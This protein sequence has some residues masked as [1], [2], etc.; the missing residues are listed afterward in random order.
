MIFSLLFFR[1]YTANTHKIL[2][3]MKRELGIE[4][5]ILYCLLPLECE[6]YRTNEALG[7]LKDDS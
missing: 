5:N 7:I 3:G 1:N 6:L 4:L 2:C